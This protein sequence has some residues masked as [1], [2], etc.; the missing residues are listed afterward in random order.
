MLAA[1]NVARTLGCS[2]DG[3]VALFENGCVISVRSPAPGQASAAP[4]KRSTFWGPARQPG[5]RSSGARPDHADRPRRAASGDASDRVSRRLSGAK[6]NASQCWRRTRP[7]HDASRRRRLF[8]VVA[9]PEVDGW[10]SSRRTKGSGT[11][12][13]S[14]PQGY[15]VVEPVLSGLPRSAIHRPVESPLG[16]ASQP[17]TLQGSP[18]ISGPLARYRANGSRT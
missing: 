3:A 5:R 14:S 13:L 7:R 8:A 16:H 1:R 9:F 12:S 11:G 4:H 10:T 17:F 6:A 18:R 2:V 15:T